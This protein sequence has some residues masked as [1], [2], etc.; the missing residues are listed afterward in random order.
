MPQ[1]SGG[2]IPRLL[3][4]YSS[5]RSRSTRWVTAPMSAGQSTIVAPQAA[6]ASFLACAVPAAPT[7]MAPAWPMRRPGGAVLPADEG[8]DRLLHLVGD[9]LGGLLLGEA[10]DLADEDDGVVSGS[11]LNMRS[12]STCVVPMTGSP[13]TPTQVLWPMPRSC[14]LG[15]RL[16]DERSRSGR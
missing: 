10:A 13:P 8:D 15:D 1:P 12:A 2:V 9:E 7:M 14:E 4:P 5:R 6:S 11:S 16:V 3:Y